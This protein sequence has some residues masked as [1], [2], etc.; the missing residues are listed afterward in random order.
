MVA[1]FSI[2]IAYTVVFLYAAELYPTTIRALG[3]NLCAAFGRIGT[4][5]APLIYGKSM[6]DKYE[7]RLAVFATLSLICGLTG[8]LV[9]KLPETKEAHLPEEIKTEQNLFDF[10]PMRF[11]GGRSHKDRRRDTYAETWAE[12]GST[13]LTNVFRLIAAMELFSSGRRRSS[14]LDRLA[15]ANAAIDDRTTIS[16]HS[17]K[18]CVG[19]PGAVPCQRSSEDLTVKP[20]QEPLSQK[21]ETKPVEAAKR[22]KQDELHVP[23]RTSEH[24]LSAES[25]PDAAPSATELAAIARPQAPSVKRS[26][27]ETGL[28]VVGS[29]GLVGKAENQPSR[30]LAECGLANTNGVSAHQ[31]A[32][33]HQPSPAIG[34]SFFEPVPLPNSDTVESNQ[35]PGS[36]VP[37][38]KS[39]SAVS[40]RRGSPG[41]RQGRVS[42]PEVGTPSAPGSPTSSPGSPLK[43]H[44]GS[45]SGV[46]TPL[47]SAGASSGAVTP[48][49][50]KTLESASSHK[51]KDRSQRLRS[52]DMP[53]GVDSG[54]VSVTETPALSSSFTDTAHTTKDSGFKKK[55]KKRQRHRHFNNRK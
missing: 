41:M 20:L 12:T 3:F 16:S 11:S 23:K 36:S 29:V 28:K 51:G 27:G 5:I 6:T 25:E 54:N 45:P 33:G 13:H 49:L 38:R 21:P 48:A 1:W 4:L 9:T 42:N 46:Q 2:N 15:A 19:G 7:W 26:S 37:A 18:P 14:R 24:A 10:A 17:N 30:S 55:T 53:S 8:F 52:P 44:S 32:A 34:G 40:S 43:L 47:S 50:A 35:A 39:S 22:Q 31:N